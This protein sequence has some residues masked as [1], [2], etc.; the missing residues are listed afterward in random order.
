MVFE[1]KEEIQIDNFEFTG[2]F[3]FC[4]KLRPNYGITVP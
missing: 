1:T 2:A 4:V 3:R